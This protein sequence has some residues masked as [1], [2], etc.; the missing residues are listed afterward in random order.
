MPDTPNA[1]AIS[2]RLRNAIED[3]AV[4][5]GFTYP[6]IVYQLID[7]DDVSLDDSGRPVG[8]RAAVV[9]LAARMPAMLKA[10]RPISG[11]TP[12]GRRVDPV[13]GHVPA[14]TTA[15]DREREVYRYLRSKISYPGA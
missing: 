15:R 12:P 2:G 10:D 8:V 7:P 14:T 5:M 13:G 11:G 6:G 4:K 3:E 9:A 1:P